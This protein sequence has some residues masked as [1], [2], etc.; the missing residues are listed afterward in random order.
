MTDKLQ[1]EDVFRPGDNVLIEMYDKGGVI[2]N[3][4]TRVEDFEDD[5]LLLQMPI[6][7]RVPV[8]LREGR[9]LTLWR[10]DDL[11][12]QAYL[13]SVQV[14]ENRPGK[15]SLLVC[16]KP[17]EI[18]ITSR[19]RFYRCSVQLP[20]TCWVDKIS[21]AGTIT[22]LSLSGFY[23]IVDP[24]PQIKAGVV[25]DLSI[26][27]PGGSFLSL[28]GEVIRDQKI[29]D[30]KKSGVAI[31]FREITEG[32][33]DILNTYLFQ[34]QRELIRRGVLFSEENDDEKDEE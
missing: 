25:L 20:L 7:Q 18:S 34:Q 16:S 26:E 14:V 2:K 19:R 17:K 10:K 24:S 23:A 15:I 29:S 33:R 1:I 3:Y 13:T 31:D 8:R 21:T 28:V 30:N 6:I 32:M 11:N 5:Y 4:N 27:M 9:E 22:D 12:K